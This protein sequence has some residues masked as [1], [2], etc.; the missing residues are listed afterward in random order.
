MI[1]SLRYKQANAYSNLSEYTCHWR[2]YLSENLAQKTQVFYFIQVGRD[3]LQ[4][5]LLGKKRGFMFH[6]HPL[7]NSTAKTVDDAA[8]AVVSSCEQKLHTV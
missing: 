2:M 1:N 7:W 5:A 6:I 8:L 3:I 4:W